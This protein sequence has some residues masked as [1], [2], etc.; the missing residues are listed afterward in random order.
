[1][2]W[3]FEEPFD[4]LLVVTLVLVCL[5]LLRA[6]PKCLLQRKVRQVAIQYDLDDDYEEPYDELDGKKLFDVEDTEVTDCED[7]EET[8]AYQT[9]SYSRLRK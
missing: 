2:P 8:P 7:V 5:F 3:Y 6:V 1:M 9:R 4:S